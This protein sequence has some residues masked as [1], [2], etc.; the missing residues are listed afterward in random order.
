[1]IKYI[2]IQFVSLSNCKNWKEEIMQNNFNESLAINY[3][4]KYKKI[5]T[6]IKIYF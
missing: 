2:V 6:L 1:M 3:I 5:K 4:M